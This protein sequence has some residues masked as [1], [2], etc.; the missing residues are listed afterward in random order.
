MNKSVSKSKTKVLDD[1]KYDTL[2]NV[3][4]YICL[5]HAEI[6]HHR[7]KTKTM[8]LKKESL[9]DVQHSPSTATSSRIL[10]ERT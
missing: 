6:Q 2:R 7:Q 8:R 4:S 3:E 1:G 5:G 9:P 10:L